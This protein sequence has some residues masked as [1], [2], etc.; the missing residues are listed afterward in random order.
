MRSKLKNAILFLF[1]LGGLLVTGAIQAKARTQKP[2]QYIAFA[3]DGSKNISMWNATREFSKSMASEQ[4]DV[5]FTYFL[6]GV[7][8]LTDANKKKYTGP[9]H[10]AGQSDIDFGGTNQDM[11]ARIEQINAASSHAEGHEM[12]SHANGHFHAEEQHWVQAD[13]EKEFGLFNKLLEGVITNN[14]LPGSAPLLKLNPE[15]E[16]KGFRAPYLEVTSGMHPTLKEYGFRYDTSG[17]ADMDYWPKKKNGVWDFPLAM[18]RIVDTNK[19]T[20]SMDYNFYVADSNATE[21]PAHSELYRD[22]MRRTY[23]KYFESNYN[24]NR[25]P[26]HIGHHFSRWNGAAY[27]NAM[28]DFAAAV[29]GKPEVKCVTYKE[30]ADYMDSL[31]TSTIAKYEQKSMRKSAPRSYSRAEVR[32]LGLTVDPAAAHEK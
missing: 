14:S 12:G 20:L 13:W 27:W 28:K 15:K 3:F 18:L 23:L 26:I 8:F 21:D 32:A 11:I 22:R 16:V 17:V 7:V 5:R 1:V 25:A 9:H 2:P 24:G 31:S 30:L 4:K 6:S 29:C 10:T 19:R